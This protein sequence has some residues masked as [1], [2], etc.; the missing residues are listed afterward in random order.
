MGLCVHKGLEIIPCPVNMEGDMN[1]VFGLVLTF[2]GKQHF[3][4]FLLLFCVA[5][6][7]NMPLL[8]IKYSRQL[9]SHLCYEPSTWA[10]SSTGSFGI[11]TATLS[12]SQVNACFPCNNVNAILLLPAFLRKDSNG[13]LWSLLLFTYK[14]FVWAWQSTV[15]IAQVLALLWERGD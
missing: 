13:I 4:E 1:G 15:L 9:S 7:L 14:Y 6:C 12:N 2:L 3:E 10:M 11:D 5:C 8:A